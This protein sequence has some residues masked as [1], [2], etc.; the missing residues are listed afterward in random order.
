MNRTPALPKSAKGWSPLTPGYWHYVDGCSIVD[1]SDL[2]QFRVFDKHKQLLA[3]QPTLEKA[4]DRH[5]YLHGHGLGWVPDLPDHR[6]LMFSRQPIV[7]LPRAVNLRSGCPP[8]YDQLLLGSCT[9]NAIAGAIGFERAK[10]R[11]GYLIPSRL[12]IYY[13]ERVIEGSVASDAG[14]SLRDGMK[15]IADQGVCSEHRWSYDPSKFASEP[16]QSA[17]LGAVPHKT[18]QYLSVA[19]DLSDMTNCLALGYP[20]VFGISVYASFQSDAAAASGVIPMPGA[21]E[22]LLGGHALLAV[23]YDL[24]AQTINFRNSWGASWGDA[25]YGTIPFA[26]LED[27]NLADDF[28]SVRLES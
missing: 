22:Q 17:Y 10:Q 20:F 2:S 11:L 24:D 6:D 28:W 3:T 9:A 4:I 7:K 12:F 14:A 1:S 27:N 15:T 25:G 5:R 16:P 18:L 13:N 21:N 19:Q 26:Y 8:V 23:G